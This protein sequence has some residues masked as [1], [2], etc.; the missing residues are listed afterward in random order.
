[1]GSDPT[2][3]AASTWPCFE[4]RVR[5]PRLELRP[6]DDE[7]ADALCRLADD[8]I[9]PPDEMP[10][11]VPWTRTPLPRRHWE[12]RQFYFRAWAELRPDAWR[13][14][15][16]VI[17][18]GEVVGQQDVDATDFPT[19]RTVG[20]GSW[21]GLAHQGRGLGTEMR[22]AMLHL[23]FAGL[24]AEV[25]ESGAWADNAASQ[26]VSDKCGYV[27][28]GRQPCP[29]DDGRRSVGFRLERARWEE[30]R[31]DDV[32]IVGLAAALPLL[33]LDQRSGEPEPT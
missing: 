29:S 31:R 21:I 15:F 3:A 17:A 20:S 16:A 22:Q 12:S 23:A 18:D 6:V 24:G 4:L 27:L 32:E 9:H 8:G 13:I 14:P 7:L 11:L 28:D 33:G 25:A 10:F 1:M 2:T 19:R 30:R 5:T 26:R